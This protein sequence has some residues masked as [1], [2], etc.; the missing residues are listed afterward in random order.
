MKDKDTKST[1]KQHFCF[2]VSDPDEVRGFEKVLQQQG[3]K[4]LGTMNWERGGRSVYFGDPDGHIGE[5]GSRGIW[6]H[7]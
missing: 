5:I 1:L 3:V 6:P 7:Y 4:I 2:A